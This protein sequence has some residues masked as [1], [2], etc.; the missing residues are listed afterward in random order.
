M[1][2]LE[3]SNEI[4]RL[5]LLH[6]NVFPCHFNTGNNL[7]DFS[8]IFLDGEFLKNGVNSKNKLASR[9]AN[10]FFYEFTF[11]ESKLKWQSWLP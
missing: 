4:N 9:E 2:P 5:D 10:S 6:L 3:V 11:I 1:D 7:R 8:I